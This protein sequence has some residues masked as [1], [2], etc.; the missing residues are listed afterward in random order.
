MKTRIEFKGFVDV[1]DETP[2]SSAEAKGW[3]EVALLRGAKHAGSY[4]TALDEVTFVSQ[5]GDDE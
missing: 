1:Y 5:V 3:V 4:V 2:M